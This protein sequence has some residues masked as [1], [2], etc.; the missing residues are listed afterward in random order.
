MPE[1]SVCFCFLSEISHTHAL[2]CGDNEW[3]GL[4]YP[5]PLHVY[6]LLE[7][8]L[9]SILVCLLK[10]AENHVWASALLFERTGNLKKRRVCH[11]LLAVVSLQSE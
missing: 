2:A 1:V 5:L 7:S 11:H 6:D 9:L 10:Q 3:F 4:F 8:H